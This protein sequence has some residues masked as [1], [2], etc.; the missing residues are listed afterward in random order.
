MQRPL[1]WSTTCLK[2]RSPKSILETAQRL[3]P[4]G[5][6]LSV[7]HS[8]TAGAIACLKNLKKAKIP[9]ILHN[10]FPAPKEPFLLNL[11]SKDKSILRKSINH[12]QKAIELSS[13][14]EAPLYAAHA[15]YTY[16]LSPELLGSPE[17]QKKLPT[18]FFGDREECMKRMAESIMTL[19]DFSVKKGVSFLIENHVLAGIGV[20]IGKKL[21]LLCEEKEF[22][23][24]AKQLDQRLSILLDTGHLKVSANSAGFNPDHFF[25]TV[26]P[27]IRAFHLSDNSG[28]TDDHLPFESSAWFLKELKS[29]PHLPATLEFSKVSEEKVLQAAQILQSS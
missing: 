27:W 3:L 7:V 29:Y 12:C 26:S 28:K 1:Y 10:Y 4:L 22:V 11:A 9:V 16:D 2:D 13:E 25:K 19:S 5:V 14:V 23:A 17:E 24:L 18:I 20:E 21:L 6:E 8:D 15:G